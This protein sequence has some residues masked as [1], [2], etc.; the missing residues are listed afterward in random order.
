MVATR[1]TACGTVRSC[2]GRAAEQSRAGQGRATLPRPASATAP[3][4]AP[5]PAPHPRGR[6]ASEACG[7][8]PAPPS[9]SRPIS[10]FHLRQ[11]LHL[12]QPSAP[13]GGGARP[14][15]RAAPLP[16]PA[17]PGPQRAH[18]RPPRARRL[19]SSQ[20]PLRSLPGGLFL[21]EDPTHTERSP[22]PSRRPG[23]RHRPAVTS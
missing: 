18:T 7:L 17:P 10:H 4:G 13:Q 22:Q 21:K 6:R 1:K 16:A 19:P 3:P 14:R 15:P 12:S 20:T 8:R 11:T 2:Y 9:P 23:G 5:G